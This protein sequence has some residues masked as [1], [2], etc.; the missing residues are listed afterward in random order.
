MELQCTKIQH[1]NPKSSQA[2]HLHHKDC[3]IFALIL[4]MGHIFHPTRLQKQNIFLPST[5]PILYCFVGE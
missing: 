5:A 3:A 2:A 1:W 4:V